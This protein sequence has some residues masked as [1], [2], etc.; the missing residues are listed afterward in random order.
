M[1]LVDERARR[2]GPAEDAFGKYTLIAKIGHGGMA[3]VFLAVSRGPAGFTKLAV[4]KRLHPHLEDEALVGMFLDEA[5]LAARLNHPHVVQT[6]EIGDAD[7]LHYLAMEYLEGQ[8]LAHVLHQCRRRGQPMPL[9]VGVRLFIDVLDG[10]HYAHTLRDF[11]GTPLHVVHRD[12]SPGNLFVTYEGQAKILDFGIAKAGTQLNETQAGQV[13]G[14]FAYIAP[15]QA[16]PGSHD[17]RADLWSL[18]VVMWEA[19]AGRRLFKG[20]SEVMTLQNTLNSQIMPLDHDEVPAPLAAIVHR[21]LQ[22]DVSRRYQS[23]AEIREDLEAYMHAASLRASRADIG[24][25]V[26]PLF[27]QERHE[28]REVLAAYMT[29]EHSIPAPSLSSTT[30]S[31]S[32]L[33]SAPTGSSMSTSSLIP[34]VQSEEVELATPF[35][36]WHLAIVLLISAILGGA[37]AAIFVR[38]GSEAPEPDWLTARAGGVEG[39]STG[40]AAEPARGNEGAN[41]APPAEDPASNEPVLPGVRVGEPVV[42]DAVGQAAERQADGNAVEALDPE[43]RAESERSEPEVAPPSAMSS[44]RRPRRPRRPRPPREQATAPAPAPAPEP[45]P[46]PAMEEAPQEAFGFLVLDTVPWSNVSLG[47][48]SLGTTPILRYRLPAGVHT[49]TLVNPERGLREQY[50]VRIRSGE[51][52]RRRVGLE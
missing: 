47:G 40:E 6:Y 22:R 2:S 26:R 50:R 32:G 41:D 19:F 27:E 36:R 34:P 52:T 3:E 13:K 38:S 35:R 49:L 45:S 31:H 51:T 15:E 23:A 46:A 8:S 7:G 24:A 12:I 5:R 1:S 39:A 21:C 30:G 44:R 43:E 9:A 16:Q 28:E 11:D 17:H 29:G 42:G 37:L 25:F 48:E 4:L 10:L 14:K 18:G 33:R 20:E